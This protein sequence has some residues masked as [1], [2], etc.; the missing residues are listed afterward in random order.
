MLL[1]QQPPEVD[2]VFS[3]IS[4]IGLQLFDL[5]LSVC[6]AVQPRIKLGQ[7]RNKLSMCLP[8]ILWWYSDVSLC[9]ALVGLCLVNFQYIFSSMSCLHIVSVCLCVKVMHGIYKHIILLLCIII[10]VFEWTCWVSSTFVQ[11][12]EDNVV[13]MFYN[14]HSSDQ[15]NSD[16]LLKVI[17]S[18]DSHVTFMHRYS[19]SA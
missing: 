15:Q 17:R 13:Q 10:V 1:S 2:W 7:L 6:I 14:V 19:I 12:I 5:Y 3:S 16:S 11:A 18:H 4:V 9:L 8:H